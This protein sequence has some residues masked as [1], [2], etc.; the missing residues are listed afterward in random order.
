M[1]IYKPFP[2]EVEMSFRNYVEYL[3][4]ARDEESNYAKFKRIILQ[5]PEVDHFSLKR[6]N[7]DYTQIKQSHKKKVFI[8]EKFSESFHRLTAGSI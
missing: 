7:F 3:C 8:L 1:G 6:I 4:H 5:N 2:K